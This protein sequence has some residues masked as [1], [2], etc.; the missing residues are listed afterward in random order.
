[1]NDANLK[2]HHH[3]VT[4]EIVFTQKGQDQIA[5][6]RING[7]LVSEQKEIPVRSLGK[8][9]QIVQM[10]FHQRMQGQEVEVVDVV[11]F[12]L[13][14]L[15]EFTQEEFHKA[16]EGTKLAEKTDAA[17]AAAND[18]LPPSTAPDQI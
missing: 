4:A 13:T 5:A 15:G 1:M 8:A 7:L 6:L 2:L 14:Y 10:N 18:E 11:I 12:N 3:L 9:Q 16:P 17:P